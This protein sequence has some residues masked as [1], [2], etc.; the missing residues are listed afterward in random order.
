MYMYIH[1]Y[2]MYTNICRGGEIGRGERGGD[3]LHQTFK[4]GRRYLNLPPIFPV[5]FVNISAAVSL[6]YTLTKQHCWQ[7]KY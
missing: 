3:G 4:W 2:Y 6:F 7:Q 5:H 1:I